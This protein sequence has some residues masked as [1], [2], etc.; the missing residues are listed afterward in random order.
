MK[1]LCESVEVFYNIQCRISFTT[2]YIWGMR[3]CV[4]VCVC[5]SVCTLVP[6]HRLEPFLFIL[7]AH[8]I[9]IFRICVNKS[10]KYCSLYV[11]LSWNVGLSS[12]SWPFR[13]IYCEENHWFIMVLNMYSKCNNDAFINST[14][15]HHKHKTTRKTRS[16]E[17]SK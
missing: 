14:T 6:A 15:F 5:V 3:V 4:C 9:T 12:L 7:Y 8:F 13:L 16:A 1:M 2:T 17:I 11:F 10:H